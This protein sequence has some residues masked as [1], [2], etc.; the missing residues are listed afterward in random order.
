MRLDSSVYLAGMWKTD[1]PLS[2]LWCQRSRLDIATFKST[3]DVERTMKHAPSLS[4]ASLLTEVESVSLSNLAAATEIVDIGIKRVPPNFYG[5]TDSCRLRLR[6]QICRFRREIRDNSTWID[7]GQHTK[8][9][10]FGDLEFQRGKSIILSWDTSRP[11]ALNFLSTD[12]S[13]STVSTYAFLHITSEHSIDGILE[14]G[15]I[16]QRTAV[17]GTYM[18]VGTFFTPFKSEY[19]GSEL[20]KA[21]QSL[22][23]TLSP[24]DYFE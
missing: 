2:M 1:L 8:F 20:E 9:Q 22:L 23:E 18:R 10:E 13:L 4:C 16:L 21:V 7:I 3:V 15:I 11:A 14:R 24:E 17:Y 12:G 5:G 6:G 19:P